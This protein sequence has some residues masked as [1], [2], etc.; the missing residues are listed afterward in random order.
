MVTVD[1]QTKKLK[2]ATTTVWL[3][4]DLWEISKQWPNKQRKCSQKNIFQGQTKTSSKRWKLF[5]HTVYPAASSACFHGNTVSGNRNRSLNLD[6]STHIYLL[7]LH[8]ISLSHLHFLSLSQKHLS[9]SYVS[10]FSPFLSLCLSHTNSLSFSPCTSLSLS[11]RL[12]RCERLVSRQ[13]LRPIKLSTSLVD[14]KD[15]NT[16]GPHG[17]C[18]QRLAQ[19][20]SCP[21]KDTDDNSYTR[22]QTSHPHTQARDLR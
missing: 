10:F 7:S 19:T 20:H 22:T 18:A 15:T 8:I 16:E 12:P 1:E 13:V 14:L 11:L 4:D 2:S 3:T 6:I 17:Q 21:L 9:L 5:S